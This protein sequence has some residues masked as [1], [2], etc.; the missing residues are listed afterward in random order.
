MLQ[1]VNKTKLVKFKYKYTVCSELGRLFVRASYLWF[2][3]FNS[4][5]LHY[6]SVGSE[7]G[8]CLQ[9]GTPSLYVTSHP[10]QLSLLPLCGKGNEYRPKYG[11]ALQLGSKGRMARSFV[12]KLVGETVW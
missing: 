2:N 7:M 4:W 3:E 6:R 11:D 12:N 10:G 8:D 5:L 9:A 1:S